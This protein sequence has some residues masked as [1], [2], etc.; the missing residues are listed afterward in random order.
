MP[1]VHAGILISVHCVPLTHD[2]SLERPVA[3]ADPELLA[4]GILELIQAAD[5]QFPECLAG[6]FDCSVLV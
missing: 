1:G 3:R 6:Q 4:A 2:E 5:R